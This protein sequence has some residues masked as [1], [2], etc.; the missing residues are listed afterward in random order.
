MTYE[1]PKITEL[2]SIADFT[3]ANS[4]AIDWDGQLFHRGTGGGGGGGTPTS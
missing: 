4:V 2:G 3:Q 1:T